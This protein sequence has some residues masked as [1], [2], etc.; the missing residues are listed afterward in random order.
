MTSADSYSF[1]DR[2]LHSFA[3][4]AIGAQKMLAEMEDDMFSA[5]MPET[6]RAPIFI[7]SLPR[8]GT[9]LLLEILAKSSDLACHTY[10][11]M[12]FVLCPMLW[13]QISAGMRKTAEKRERAHGDG[14]SVD[15]DS[16]EAF[17]EILWLAFWRDK[18]E[19]DRIA[20]WTAADRNEDFEAFFF[21]HMRKIIA[22]RRPDAPGARYVS[23][24]NANVA[25]LPLLKAMA[26]DCRI[27][28]PLRHPAG[29]IA[30]LMR[31]HE[32]FVKV[33]G[34]DPFGL[35][36]MS[37]IGHFEFGAA[38]KPID[39]SGWTTRVQQGPDHP[40]FWLSYWRAAYSAIAKAP[41]AL[42]FD[43]EGACADPH[44]HLDRLLR[45]VDVPASD[46]LRAEAARFRPSPYEPSFPETANADL[47]AQV[48]S[49][50]EQLRA[51]AL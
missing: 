17:E 43:Y 30:S 44:P 47:T 11:D 20:P 29:Q 18:F 10:R 1:L 8:A 16:P 13:E 9:T 14:M 28:V 24:N 50:Y 32:R 5:R 6:T 3:F 21:A 2:Q 42:I 35:K 45:A 15:F 25:R 4:N 49:L 51:Q 22:L 46:S 7:T 39:F 31:Q 41:D 34:E 36:Y 19:A 37:W 23:K 27:V 48:L 26:P 12:P 38:L 33:H 40:D